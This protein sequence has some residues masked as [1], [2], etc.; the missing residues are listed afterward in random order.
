MEVESL[1]VPIDGIYFDFKL[2]AKVSHD[3]Y[4]K[5]C[6]DFIELVEELDLL[7][8][9]GFTDIGGGGVVTLDNSE[10]SIEQLKAVVTDYFKSRCELEYLSEIEVDSNDET[11]GGQ[12]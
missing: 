8:G 7:L 6:D 2:K 10:L 4:H 3:E 12:V 1:V 11:L 5:L 9:G